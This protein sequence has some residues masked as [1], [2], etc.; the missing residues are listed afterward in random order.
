MQIQTECCI[1]RKTHYLLSIHDT[2]G[3]KGI[4]KQNFI[5]MRK[6]NS[7]VK[8]I[9]DE[10]TAKDSDGSTK[11]VTT[12]NIQGTSLYITNDDIGGDDAEEERRG[13]RKRGVEPRS[14]RDVVVNGVD[15]HVMT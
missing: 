11:D 1:H 7:E 6:H 3:T 12:K 15:C 2:K 14:Y 13:E 10:P 4:R 9:D 8:K 5:G